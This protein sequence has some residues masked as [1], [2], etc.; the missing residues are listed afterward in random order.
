[1]FFIVGFKREGRAI[2]KDMSKVYFDKST[3]DLLRLR[4][5]KNRKIERIES[6]AAGYWVNRDLRELR[7]QVTWINAVLESRNCQVPFPEA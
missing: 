4:S 2:M 5:E 3:K 7:Q 6:G 1:M